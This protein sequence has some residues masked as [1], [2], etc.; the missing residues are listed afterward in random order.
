[1]GNFLCLK[2]VIKNYV[3]NGLCKIIVLIWFG[4]VERIFIGILISFLICLI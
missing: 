3:I 4:F 2:V 1:M